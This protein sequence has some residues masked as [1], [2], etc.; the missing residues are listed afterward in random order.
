MKADVRAAGGGD[1]AADCAV[2]HSV[3]DDAHRRLLLKRTRRRLAPRQVGHQREQR[4][5]WHGTGR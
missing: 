5:T 3:R 4:R 1:S 2:R